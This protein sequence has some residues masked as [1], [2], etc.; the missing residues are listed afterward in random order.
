MFTTAV[1]LISTQILL[2]FFAYF[3][4]LIAPLLNSLQ[5]GFAIAPPNPPVYQKV[6]GWGWGTR[7][8]ILEFEWKTGKKFVF[9]S[10]VFSLKVLISNFA[11]AYGQFPVYQM[12][13]ILTIPF[14]L[15]FATYLQSQTLPVTTLSSALSI[16][17]GLFMTS[18]RHVRFAPEGFITGLFSSF[19]TALY[20]FTLLQAYNIMLENLNTGPTSPGGN[21]ISYEDHQRAFWRL[22]YYVNTFS[23]MFI[24]PLSIITGAWHEV[25]RTCYFL[26]AGFFWFMLGLSGLIATIC[27]VFLLGMVR[28]TSPLDAIVANGPR[29][30]STTALLSYFRMQVYSWVGFL[31]TWASAWWYLKG[32]K[33]NYKWEKDGRGRNGGTYEMH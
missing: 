1:Q 21:N 4:R 14:A 16:T 22:L 33:E 10:A 26:D 17:F 7:G 13:R 6:Q 15:F 28:L 18:L 27:F 20:P 2:I 29:A 32:R 19:F 31:M 12:S 25:Y 9:V 30:A 23:L 24:L 5:F 3:T 11:F 8:G